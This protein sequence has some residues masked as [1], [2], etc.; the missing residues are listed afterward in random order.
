MNVSI[1][2]TY[3]SHKNVQGSVVK[4][5]GLDQFGHRVSGTT[6][7]G[8]YPILASQENVSV[9]YLKKAIYDDIKFQLFDLE[10]AVL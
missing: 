8:P 1:K 6:H 10:I 4:E 7:L 5:V 2:R 9:D 3:K